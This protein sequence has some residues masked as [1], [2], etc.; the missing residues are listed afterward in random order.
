MNNNTRDNNLYIIQSL[1]NS[2]LDG[3]SS[4]KKLKEFEEKLLNLMDDNNGYILK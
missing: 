1:T 3:F 2:E 4:F